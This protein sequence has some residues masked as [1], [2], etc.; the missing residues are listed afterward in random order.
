[1]MEFYQQGQN[2]QQNAINS[3]FGSPQG[4]PA[5]MTGGESLAQGGAGFLSSDAFSDLVKGIS[6]GNNGTQTSPAA[7]GTTAPRP[8]YSTDWNQ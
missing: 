1:M 3:I 7:P 5:K 6:G 4:A 2:R 8:G